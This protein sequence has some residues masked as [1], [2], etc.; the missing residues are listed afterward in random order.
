MSGRKREL[1]ACQTGAECPYLADCSGGCGYCQDC[2]EC[3]FDDYG[4][5]DQRLDEDEQSE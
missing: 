1:G 2:C 5:E 3:D 4:L